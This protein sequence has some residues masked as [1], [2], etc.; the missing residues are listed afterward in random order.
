MRKGGVPALSIRSGDDYI[1]KEKGWA[2]KFFAEYN[3]NNYHQPS[4]EF[5]DEWQFD[6]MVQMLDVTF[7]IAM[8][9]SNA[10]K[11]QAFKQSDEFAK[12]QPNRK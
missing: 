11:L 6:G 4:D 2:D 9:V 5:D 8:R 12:A 1:G 3:K 7:G 10:P